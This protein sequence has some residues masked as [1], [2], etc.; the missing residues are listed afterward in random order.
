[1]IFQ[2]IFTSVSACA[3]L[4]HISIFCI[5]SARTDFMKSRNE[6]KHLWFSPNSSMNHLDATYINREIL[7]LNT[8]KVHFQQILGR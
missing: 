7:Q 8:L 2:F 6:Q 5:A 3:I 1:M 4:I